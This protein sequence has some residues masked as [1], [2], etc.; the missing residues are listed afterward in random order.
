MVALE[1]LGSIQCDVDVCVASKVNSKVKSQG[2]YHIIFKCRF[3]NETSMLTTTK[4]TL[5]F[6]RFLKIM[7]LCFS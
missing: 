2:S 5:Y 7:S 4:S 1:K 6:N 3:W